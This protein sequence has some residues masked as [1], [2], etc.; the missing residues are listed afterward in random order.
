MAALALAAASPEPVVHGQSGP[1]VELISLGTNGLSANHQSGSDGSIPARTRISADGRYVVFESYAVQRR[2]RTPTARR[3]TSSC[4]TASRAPSTA[5]ERRLGRQPGQPRLVR[6]GDQRR[7]PVRR[8]RQ[9]G[10]QPRARPDPNGSPTSSGAICRRA[11]RRWCRRLVVR[12]ARELRLPRSGHL[13]GTGGRGL[14][15][16]RLEPGAGRPQ[17]HGGTCSRG[18]WWRA[19]S[20]GSACRP[21][22][23]RGL[24]CDAVNASITADGR[25]V[26]FLTQSQ[27]DPSAFNQRQE[28]FLR[29]RVAGTTT[30]VMPAADGTLSTRRHPLRRD[31]RRRPIRGLPEQQ[32]RHRRARRQRLHPRRLP[33][34]PPRPAP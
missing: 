3:R 10:H 26:L 17:W 4:A 2:V 6:P 7:R 32:Q 19:P 27:L 33:Q 5:G 16:Q 11:R 1:G 25:Y 23:W 28:M 15:Q 24:C 29:D 31:Q 8:L 13:A 21:R 14:L 18:T 20:S 34:G 22:A 30:I 9:P 12:R